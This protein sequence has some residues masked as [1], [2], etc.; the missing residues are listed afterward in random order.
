MCKI[1]EAF[2][3]IQQVTFATKID[4]IMSADMDAFTLVNEPVVLSKFLFTDETRKNFGNTY[5]YIS[6]VPQYNVV[7]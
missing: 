5:P 6:F 1:S 3:L 4:L 7:S 2:L